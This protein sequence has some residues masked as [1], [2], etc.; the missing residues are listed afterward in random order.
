MT[1]MKRVMK[2][3]FMVISLNDYQVKKI[4]FSQ[5]A[6][7]IHNLIMT[8]NF[9]I[10]EKYLSFVFGLFITMINVRYGN[11]LDA[12]NFEMDLLLSSCVSV[13]CCCIGDS[14]VNSISELILSRFC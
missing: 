4:L 3:A 8:N 5:V 1:K 10:K 11:S 13:I 12:T 9:T 14:S 7:Y 6:I 2:I